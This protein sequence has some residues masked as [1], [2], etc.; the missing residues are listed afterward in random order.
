MRQ[1]ICWD[2]ETALIRPGKHAPELVCCTWLRATP[3]SPNTWEREAPEI[4]HHTEALP[5]FRAWLRGNALLVGHNVAFDMGVMGANFPE[6]VP[7]IFDAY[8]Q[9]RVTD[10][11]IR[12]KLLDIASGTYRGKLGENDE[13]VKINYHLSDL[14]KK[15]AGRF[16]VKD[17]WRMYYNEF[18]DV[19]IARWPEHAVTVQAKFRPD[20]DRLMAEQRQDPKK[21]DKKQLLAD[22]R[23]LCTSPPEGCVEYPLGDAVGTA[24][25][26]FGQERHADPYLQDQ[27]RAVRKDF[28]LHLMSTWGLRTSHAGVARLRKEAEALH[29]EV[30]ARLVLAGLVR[31]N[32]VRDT[33]AAKE[34]MVSVCTGEG[35]PVRMTKPTETNPDGG[36][37]LDEDACK[38]TED[39]VLHDYAK[40]SKLSKVLSNDV[41][42][43]SMGTVFPIHT[44][45]GMAETGRTTSAN[46]NVQNWGKKGGARECFR[47]RDGFVFGNTDV[48][49]LELR[50]LAQV[51][52]SKL[53]HSTLGKVLNAGRDPHTAFACKILGMAYEEGMRLKEANDVAFDDVRQGCKFTNFALPGGVGPAKMVV[54]ARKAGIDLGKGQGEEASLAKAKELKRDWLN[55]WE[56]MPEYFR[57]INSLKADDGDYYNLVQLFTNRYRGG[58]RYT[59]ACNSWFQGLGA[60]ATGR[61]GWY[62]ARACYVDRASPLFGCR[63]V[64]YAHDDML[65]EIP[66]N[67]RAHDAAEELAKQFIRG[68]NEYLPDVPATSKPLLTRVWTKKSKR[69]V[70]PDGRLMVWVP[71]AA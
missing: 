4:R 32:G 11:M 19:P 66:E 23:E 54:I 26:F 47:P 55:M 10:T 27:F 45:F 6:L 67:D 61:G 5:I 15:W 50:T 14:V 31:P 65:V 64:N 43:L 29:E 7:E 41:K 28:W 42:A 40:Y 58:A 48:D 53:G 33:K 68:I 20:L 56:E 3:T 17:G 70:G 63:P 35:R 46:P 21:F 71:E 34:R 38:A 52:I 60:D 44:H 2:T 16:M 9:D 69:V 62:V 1:V 12:E 24:D 59:A 39:D 25:A 37:C 13:W 22:L 30:K 49:Q 36:V 18:R 57:F 8:D 51:C